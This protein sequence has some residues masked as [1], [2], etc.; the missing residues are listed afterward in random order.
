MN[1]RDQDIRA[2]ESSLTSLKESMGAE[3]A[4]KSRDFDS[5]KRAYEDL[6]R[7]HDIV[8][9][10]LKVR[11]DELDSAHSMNRELQAHATAL[12]DKGGY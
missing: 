3:Y 2:L 5:V 10:S 8:Q 7:Q 6:S 12:L 11:N 1:Q 9:E 4:A